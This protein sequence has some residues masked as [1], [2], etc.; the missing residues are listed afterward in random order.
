MTLPRSVKEILS[1]RIDDDAGAFQRCHQLQAIDLQYVTTIGIR[2]FSKCSGLTDI[3]F[4]ASPTALGAAAFSGCTS[5]KEVTLP[6]ILSV[7]YGLF[8]GCCELTTLR[9]QDSEIVPSLRDL[10]MLETVCFYADGAYR[11]ILTEAD[12]PYL[13][14]LQLDDWRYI[15]DRFYGTPYYARYREVRC[16]M[17]HR[18]PHCLHRMKKGLLTGRYRCRYCR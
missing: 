7:G 13:T 6:P 1:T 3:R 17:E 8:D 18:C 4:S 9:L 12:Y 11:D 2:A 16:E 14:K 15:R 5:L 10:P